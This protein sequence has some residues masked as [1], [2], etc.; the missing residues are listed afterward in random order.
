MDRGRAGRFGGPSLPAG[1]MVH[2]GRGA[3]GKPDRAVEAPVT[4]DSLL[5]IL[6]MALVT[7]LTRV[8]GPFLVPLVR[9]NQRLEGCLAK[10]PGS[11]LV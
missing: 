1:Q 11:I 7:Y 6:G 10:L 9:G 3:G 5:A 4:Q 2:R 8:I